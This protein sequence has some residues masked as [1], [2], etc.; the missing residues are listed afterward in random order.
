MYL[1]LDPLGL[2]FITPSGLKTSEE[3][4]QAVKEFAT[5]RDV[6]AVR[7]FLGLASYY[8]RFVPLFAKLAHSLHAL[9]R[10][11]AVFDWDSNCQKAF[12]SLKQ[13][14]KEAPVLA[15][16]QFDRNFILE[17]D[18][19]GMGLGAVLSQVQEDGKPHPIA[20]A[21]RALSPCEKK[22]R[23][24]RVGDP[25]CGVVHLALQELFVWAGGDGIYGPL[26]SWCSFAE[27]WSWWKTCKMVAEGA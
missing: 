15:Y 12:D 23:N 14:L 27:A 11:G 8:R 18:A 3:H 5:P 13:R 9:T 10:K 21:S 24:Y 17:T 16:P 1:S 6:H 2:P 22:L 26:S 4:V 25:S 7:R 19:S 20:F